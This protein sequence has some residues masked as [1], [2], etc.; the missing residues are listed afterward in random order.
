MANL[1]NA[2]L[3]QSSTDWFWVEDDASI[4]QFERHEGSLDLTQL[5]DNDDCT[6]IAQQYLTTVAYPQVSITVG[7]ESTQSY[8]AAYVNFLP[9]DTITGPDEDDSGTAFHVA[10]L[11]VSHDDEGYAIMVPVLDTPKLDAW[12]KFQAQ[13]KAKS[14]SLGGQ[15]DRANPLQ[16]E[17]DTVVNGKVPGDTLPPFSFSGLVATGKATPTTN[18]EK[19][20]RVTMIT[21]KCPPSTDSDD[22]S[23]GGHAGYTGTGDSTKF[24]VFRRLSGSTAP[25]DL[26]GLLGG[27][28]PDPDHPGVITMGPTDTQVDV[29]VG[30]EFISKFD[31]VW[32]ACLQ[33]GGHN[34]CTVIVRVAP[35]L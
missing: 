26:I 7:V 3:V 12:L 31:D 35:V 10:E 16:A 20:V 18:P 5:D 30:N 9:G 2:I 32:A 1:V 34:D 11:D 6:R 29:Y 25:P 14:G 22:D 17:F 19:D 24:V 4:D 23:G 15:A 21:V 27:A 8:D 33:G 13:L 28:W